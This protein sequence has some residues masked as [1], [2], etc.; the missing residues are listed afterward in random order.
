MILIWTSRRLHHSTNDAD[1]LRRKF[2]DSTRMLIEETRR[3]Y[4]RQILSLEQRL[5]SQQRAA[6]ERMRIHDNEMRQLS[7]IEFSN[8]AADTLAKESINLKRANNENI[9]TILNPLKDR[10]ADFNKTVTELITKENASRSILSQHIETLAGSNR[11]I[12]NEAR[13]LANALKGNTRIQGQW[14]EN[15]LQKILE[16][17][18]LIS[19]I[20][21]MMQ[22]GSIDGAAVRSEEGE[23]YRPDCVI[24]LPGSQKVVIDVKTS[25][26]YYLRYT[27]TEDEAQ[28]ELQL[29][30]H[31]ISVRKHI[32]ELAEKQYHRHISGAMEHTLMFMP[33][34][35]AFISALRQDPDI[36]E[37]AMRN[38]IAIVAPA[39]ILSIIQ[40][41]SQ[42][43]RI[44]RQNNNAEAIAEAAG[45]LYDRFV[46]FTKDLE[47]IERNLQSSVKAYESC[48]NHLTGGSQSLAARAERLRDMGAKVTRRIPD[49][50]IDRT[51]EQEK[52]TRS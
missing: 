6:E 20:H 37:Y 41:I 35:G 1:E 16:N 27:E 50:L 49:N 10:L 29:R 14:G 19:G 43:W 25:L 11:I 21:F 2:E 31:A 40:L 18:G 38:N 47:K 44:E 39:H 51:S 13:R 46:I 5:E 12:S 45:K 9:D 33:N 36:N 52:T 48:M 32:K 4:E 23:S 24:L 30:N 28:A 15:V 22:S 3:E 26:T 7:A 34:E 42:L 8:L 17:S